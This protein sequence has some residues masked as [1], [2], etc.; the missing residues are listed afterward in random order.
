MYLAAGVC[1]HRPVDSH[2]EVRVPLATEELTQFQLDRYSRQIRLEGFGLEGQKALR[3]AHVVISRGGGVGGT[4]AAHLALAGV[5]RLTIAHDGKVVPEYL[6]RW[7]LAFPDD[8]G[9]PCADAFADSLHRINPDI[10]VTTISEYVSDDNAFD[11]AGD[12]DMIADGAPLFEERYALNRVA[13]TNRIPMVSGAMYD[14]EGYILT[15]RPGETPCLACVYPVKPAYWRDV[16]VFPVISP[17]SG[18]VGT[19]MAMEVIKVLTGF[20]PPLDS[21]LMFFDLRTN[22]VRLFDVARQPGCLVCSGL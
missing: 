5:G 14:T 18:M 11:I 17:I 7:P 21:Q 6:N 13:I 3:D 15:V 22:M 16:S 10:D 1:E 20:A 4:V 2:E 8:V 9:R 19:I 12:A